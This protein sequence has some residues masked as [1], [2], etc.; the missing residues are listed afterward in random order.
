MEEK[1]FS[2]ELQDV[3]AYMTDILDKEFP[4]LIFTPE[5]L[6]TSILDNKKCRAYLLLNNCLVS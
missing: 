4:S 6:I 5:Y 1:N 2:K 3:L